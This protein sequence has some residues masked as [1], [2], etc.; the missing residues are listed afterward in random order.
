MLRLQGILPLH[1]LGASLFLVKC[2]LLAAR[3]LGIHRSLVHTERQR[4]V[5]RC[6]WTAITATVAGLASH[7]SETISR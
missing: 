2:G 7:R 6:F 1:R 5:T 3:L 4:D